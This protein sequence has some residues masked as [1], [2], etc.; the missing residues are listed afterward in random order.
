MSPKK[1]TRPFLTVAAFAIASCVT[2]LGVAWPSATYADGDLPLVQYTVDGA[3]IGNV[4]VRGR[5]EKDAK[6][7]SGWS[8]VVTAE[9]KSDSPATVP[10][11]TDLTRTV[12]NPMARSMPM[13]QTAWNA[14]DDVTLAAHQTMTRRY[15]LPVAIGQEIT[16]ARAQEQVSA[17]AQSKTP[18]IAMRTQTFFAVSFQ[19]E[20][21]ASSQRATASG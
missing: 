19:R 16:K 15:E 10:L 7:K 5:L 2:T 9:N 6:A 8:I 11:E 12:A 1:T 3:K 17:H 14:K 21:L 18:I 13:P 4:L 20:Q